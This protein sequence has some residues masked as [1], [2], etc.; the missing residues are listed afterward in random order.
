MARQRAQDPNRPDGNRA[1]IVLVQCDIVTVVHQIYRQD[2]TAEPG[3]FYEAFTFDAYRVKNGK[4]VEH[5]DNQLINAPAPAARAQVTGK[6]YTVL[7]AKGPA[8]LRLVST[9]CYAKPSATKPFTCNGNYYFSDCL[10]G[11]R[12]TTS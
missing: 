6:R 8:K 11:A 3:K 10:S 12:G 7:N 2:P 1:E 9:E 4:V 5:W